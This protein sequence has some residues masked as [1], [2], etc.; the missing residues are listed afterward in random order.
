MNQKEIIDYIVSNDKSYHNACFVGYN[1]NELVKIKI[2]I[3]IEK[4]KDL[5]NKQKKLSNGGTH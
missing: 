5:I 2:K 1:I 4:D 3:E